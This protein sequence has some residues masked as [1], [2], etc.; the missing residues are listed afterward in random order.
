MPT[1]L[2]SLAGVLLAAAAAPADDWPQ[3]MGPNRDNVWRETGLLDAFPAGGPKVVWRAKVA[4]GFAGP[5]VSGGKVFVTDYVTQG[6]PELPNFERTVEVS[7]MERVLCFEEATGKPLWKHEYPVKYTV[8]YPAGPRCTPAVRAGKVYTLGTEG[9]LLCLE[10]DTGKVVWGKDLKATYKTKSPLWG[11]AAHP[12]IDG[13]K[14]IT[15]AGGEGSHV[16]ALDTDT[17]AELWKANTQKET[18]Y[19]PPVIVEAGGVRQLIVCGPSLVCGLDPETGKRH[20]AAP[21]SAD[22][23]AVIMTPVR[24]GDFLYVGAYSNKN[25]LLKLAADKPAAAVV[26]KDKGKAGI[27]PVNVQPIVADGV[28]Y[29]LHED[30]MMF[31]V[32]VATGKRLWE[33]GGPLGEDPQESGSAFIV[34]QGDRYW[35]FAETGHLVIA[36]LTPKG[37]EEVSR[38]RLLDPTTGAFGR[39]VV[40]SHPAYADRCAFLRNDKEIVCV[41]LAKD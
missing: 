32:E 35:L 15:L 31:G 37:Y 38:A 7:G 28:M 23:G 41:S 2:A 19:A 20:W 21:L 3:W 39:K 40:W 18:G 36:R 1:R 10:A 29:G 26:F 8:S 25:L 16:V 5:A 24:S 27:S 22:N 12:L 14:L 17:G 4:G 9:S 34:R 33:S 30:G 11:Y 13:K 6:N